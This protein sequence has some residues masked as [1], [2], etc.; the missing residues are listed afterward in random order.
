MKNLKLII[1]GCIITAL[2]ICGQALAGFDVTGGSGSANFDYSAYGKGV[3]L[4]TVIGGQTVLLKNQICR[5][6]A[7]IGE[8]NF[9]GNG[10]ITL[11]NG[12]G[13]VGGMQGFNI[14][15]TTK[16]ASASDMTGA[17]S[18]VN[19]NGNA[20]EFVQSSTWSQNLLKVYVPH[21]TFGRR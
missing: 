13:E 2:S 14:T 18:A 1:L 8:N 15:A 4:N 16:S 12:Q 3:Q 20:S 5:P 9:S 6:P 11:R 10:N 7:L 19:G 17:Y 21:F